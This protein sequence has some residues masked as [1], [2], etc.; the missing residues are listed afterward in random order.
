[1]LRPPRDPQPGSQ[2]GN[3]GTLGADHPCMGCKVDSPCKNSWFVFFCSGASPPTPVQTAQ[4]GML[5]VPRAGR[6]WGR[7]C[8]TMARQ[9]LQQSRCKQQHGSHTVTCSAER[10]GGYF[11]TMCQT[12]TRRREPRPSPPSTATERPD[13]ALLSSSGTH[14]T[15]KGHETVNLVPPRNAKQKRQTNKTIKNWVSQHPSTPPQIR[16]SPHPSHPHTAALSV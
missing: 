2:R 7:L 12:L 11:Y 15:A 16:V 14:C 4:Q 1:M 10:S 8:P 3:W 9:H 5:P 13:R 6:S